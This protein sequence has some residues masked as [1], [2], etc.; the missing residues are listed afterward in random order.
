MAVKSCSPRG[1]HRL[2]VP[3]SSLSRVGPFC[4]RHLPLFVGEPSL[5][6]AGDGFRSCSHLT[7]P[8]VLSSRFAVA[9]ERA[10]RAAAM[11]R[12]SRAA[13][14]V[15]LRQSESS[16][17]GLRSQS[18]A[19][20]SMVAGGWGG[21]GTRSQRRPAARFVTRAAAR[22]STYLDGKRYRISVKQVLKQAWLRHGNGGVFSLGRDSPPMTRQRSD[23]MRNIAAGDHSSSGRSSSRISAQRISTP[24]LD[25]D[26]ALSIEDFSEVAGLAEDKLVCSE[27]L[28]EMKS[29]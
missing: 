17:Q 12:A 14:R 26:V 16:R 10:S 2:T 18:Q 7:A 6:R 24:S 9:M 20:A 15:E 22:D 11:E 21:A 28:C 3:W 23:S 13:A 29:S 25:F 5:P 27:I 8:P 4:Q 1:K 19:R